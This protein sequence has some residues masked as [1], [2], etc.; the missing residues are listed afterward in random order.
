MER[1]AR[2]DVGFFRM[3][4]GVVLSSAAVIG[5]IVAWLA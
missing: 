5:A 3:L 2:P 4:L 1:R